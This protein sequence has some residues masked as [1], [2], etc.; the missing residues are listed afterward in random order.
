MDGQPGW[1]FCDKCFGMFFDGHPENKGH[2]P[3]GGPHHGQ[4]F[5]F[6][7]AHRG[8]PTPHITVTPNGGHSVEVKGTG[9]EPN[10]EALL[11]WEYNPPF[12]QHT[13]PENVATDASGNFTYVISGLAPSVNSVN[14]KAFDTGSGETAPGSL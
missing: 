1:R 4:G 7:L 11:T 13:V 5:V 8:F 3:A 14:V 9:F 12:G 2:C 10:Q 6:Y